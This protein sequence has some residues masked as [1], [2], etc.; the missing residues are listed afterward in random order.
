MKTNRKSIS[1]SGRFWS[2]LQANAMLHKCSMAHLVELAVAQALDTVPP[3]NR[4][5]GPG[6]RK[7]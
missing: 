2:R 5:R 1:V 3:R 4:A 7:G 6:R